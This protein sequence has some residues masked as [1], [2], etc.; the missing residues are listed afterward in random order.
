MSDSSIACLLVTHLPVKAERQRYPVLRGKPLV[1]V[2]NRRARELAFDI[3]P[4]ARGVKPGMTLPEVLARCPG[5]TLLP[6]DHRFYGDVFDRMADNIAMRCPVVERAE[7]GCI[8]AS[9][10]GMSPLYGGEARLIASLLQSV[11]PDFGLRVGV[12]S[13]KFEAHVSAA[14]ALPGRAVK[15]QLDS[16]GF[17]NSHSIDP[18]ISP[19]AGARL[20]RSGIT[21]IEQLAA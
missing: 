1:V 19:Q 8:Y 20:R 4:E 5:A 21:A 14:T 13:G 11:P 18:L 15:A 9:L 6:A 10:E 12:A 3:S 17:L 7:L 16:A 2:E